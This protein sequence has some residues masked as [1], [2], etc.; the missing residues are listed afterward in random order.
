MARAAHQPE[1]LGQLQ[2]LAEATLSAL[3]GGRVA[4]LPA[5]PLLPTVTLRISNRMTRSAGVYRPPG[6]IAISGHFLAAH[7]PAGT[8]GIVLH[9]LAHH[10]TRYLHGGAATPHGDAFLAVASALGASRYAES[11]PAP[12]LVYVYRCPVCGLEWKRGRRTR[13]GRRYS[14]RRC[15]PRYDDRFRFVFTGMRRDA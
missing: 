14:C 8:R 1:V 12:R 11:F 2:G 5:A 4:G 9:E 10:V 13:A 15:A 7:G 3:R 6:D